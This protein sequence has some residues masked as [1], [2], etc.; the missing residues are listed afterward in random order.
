MYKDKMF[1]FF[2]KN[3]EKDLPKVN[4]QKVGN[5]YWKLGLDDEIVIFRK[6]ILQS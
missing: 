3:S 4:T 5:V 6:Y 2:F 1:Y